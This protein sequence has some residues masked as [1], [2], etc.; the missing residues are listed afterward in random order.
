MNVQPLSLH[1]AALLVQKPIADNRGSFARTFCGR[2]LAEHGLSF[3]MAQCNEAFNKHARTLR[4]MHFQRPP[5]G[6][7]KIVN[8]VQGKLYDVIVDLNLDSPTF[9]KWVGVTLSA[10]DGQSLFVPKGFAHGYQTLTENT[11]IQ[12]MVSEYYTPSHESGVRWNDPFFGIE[13]PFT[14]DLLLSEKDRSWTDFD[15]MRDGIRL[16]EGVRT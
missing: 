3:R 6:E 2:T 13:W 5:H 9:G 14:E 16:S 4:G 8:C 12:Y 11:V 7:E 10:D 15:K 1:G